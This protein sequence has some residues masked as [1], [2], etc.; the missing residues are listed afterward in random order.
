[1]VAALEA[2]YVYTDALVGA[3]VG[4]F[5]PGDLVLVVSD[6]GFEAGVRLGYL[7]GVHQS[8]AAAEGVLFAR[9]PGIRAGA[10]AGPVAIEDVTPTVLAWLGLPAAA[11][12]DGRPAP[13]L[14]ARPA[15]SVA[16]YDGTPIER[17]APS[18]SGA[19]GAIVEQLRELGY[20]E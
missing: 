10:P 8:A 14:A 1:M 15:G 19:E 16:S 17:L 9:G 3:L 6:H 4:R 12:M 11:D 20:V 2:Y 7:T 18:Q 5:G 13:F